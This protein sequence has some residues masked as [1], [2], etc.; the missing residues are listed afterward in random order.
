MPAAPTVAAPVAPTAFAPVA[1]TAI[2]APRNP[3][4]NPEYL[5]ALAAYNAA[6]AQRRARMVDVIDLAPASAPASARAPAA[7]A[8]APSAA[9]R[10]RSVLATVAIVVLLCAVAAALGFFLVDVVL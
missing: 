5:A 8:R 3:L 10:G 7:A 1:P 6:E 2:A 9:P 4:D